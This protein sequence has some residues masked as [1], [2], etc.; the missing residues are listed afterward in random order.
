LNYKYDELV[1]T[2][3]DGAHRKCPWG[4]NKKVHIRPE[5]SAL[6]VQGVVFFRGREALYTWYAECL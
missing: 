6:G 5:G 2:N 4:A 3:T 1:K